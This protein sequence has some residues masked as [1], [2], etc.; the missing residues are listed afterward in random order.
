[1]FSSIFE[2]TVTQLLVWELVRKI[3]EKTFREKLHANFLLCLYHMPPF[4]HVLISESLI[5]QGSLTD[6]KLLQ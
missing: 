4:I 2:T 3:I 6:M 5:V 1:M